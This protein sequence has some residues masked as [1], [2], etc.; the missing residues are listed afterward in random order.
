MNYSQSHITD[1]SQA[2]F[3]NGNVNLE[4]SSTPAAGFSMSSSQAVPWNLLY[5][6]VVFLVSVGIIVL[7]QR[8]YSSDVRV[9]YPSDLTK[10]VSYLVGEASRWHT[11]AQQD[12]NPSVALMHSAYAVAYCNAARFL[13]DDAEIMRTV[14]VHMPELSMVTANTQQA[15]FQ[16]L[17]SS[18]AGIA[19]S[20]REGYSFYS[21]Y[22]A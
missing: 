1:T 8:V 5:V 6:V 7:N 15:A 20:D 16:A 4:N 19:P 17:T 13:M 14:G 3:H 11:V 18:C 9:S 2:A 21:G 10:H 12:T 22:S